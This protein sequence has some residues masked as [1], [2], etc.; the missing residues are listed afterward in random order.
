MDL[1]ERILN[2]LRGRLNIVVAHT[3]DD[4]RLVVEGMTA[5]AEAFGWADMP[6]EMRVK[7][8]VYCCSQERNEAAP[9]VFVFADEVTVVDAP[10]WM[11]IQACSEMMEHEEEDEEEEA[12][13][14]EDN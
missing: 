7:R 2:S 1:T 11:V 6:Q 13:E 8:D 9:L 5:D 4:C 10:A 14:E 3:S 12:D